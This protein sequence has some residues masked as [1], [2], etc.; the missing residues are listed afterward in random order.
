MAAYDITAIDIKQALDRE[1]I[2]LPSGSIEGDN[3][4][5]TIRTLGLMVSTEEFNNLI[6]KESDHNI[7]RLRDI[8]QAELGPENHRSI[9]K[10]N[11]IPMVSVV[12]IPQPG[13]NQINISDEVKKR[14]KEMEKDLPEDIKLGLV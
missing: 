14:I 8:G 5:L 3:V 2:E 7:V 1:N 11:G 6:I 4:E 9:L 13:A 12:I 10:R